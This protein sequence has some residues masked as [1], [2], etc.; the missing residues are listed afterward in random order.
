MSEQAIGATTWVI[1]DGCIPPDSTG[2]EPEMTSHD[3]A[4][5]TTIA[6]PGGER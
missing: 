2:L 6:Y 1:A 4:L 3:S 5:M